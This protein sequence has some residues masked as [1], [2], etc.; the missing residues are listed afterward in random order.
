MK[1]EIKF[2]SQFKKDIKKAQKQNKDLNKLFEVVELLAK[3]EKLHPKHRD[4]ALSGNYKDIRDYHIE[5]DWLLLYTYN[6]KTMILSLIRVGS[7]SELF[8]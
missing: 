8:D 2:T 1:Y 3:G 5:S 7:H 4:H 6:K